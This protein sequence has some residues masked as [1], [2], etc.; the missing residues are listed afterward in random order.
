MWL[1]FPV[2]WCVG[3]PNVRLRPAG[4]QPGAGRCL[5]LCLAR[6]SRG[7]LQ[8]LF[9]V[10]ATISNPALETSRSLFFPLARAWQASSLWPVC[11]DVQVCELHI[12]AVWLVQEHKQFCSFL[13]SGLLAWHE[14]DVLGDPSVR[15][16]M[17]PGLCRAAELPPAPRVG[18]RA[19]K[20]CYLWE[21][22][23]G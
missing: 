10:E 18:L 1:V 19:K 22:V 14:G 11:Q 15:A 2:F 20:F 23:P 17:R 13:P 9:Q 21:K 4:A 16:G 12:Q 3:S 8:P 5:P 6:A 7:C